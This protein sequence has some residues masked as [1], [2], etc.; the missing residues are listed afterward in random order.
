MRTDIHS[1]K[2]I[3]PENYNFVACKYLGTGLADWSYLHQ[4]NNII[5]QHKK[6]TEGRMASHEHGGTCHICGAYALYIAVFHHPPTNEYIET[7]FDCAEK[8]EISAQGM[9]LFQKRVRAELQIMKGK[10]AALHKLD[11]Y[12]LPHLKHH[13]TAS[14]EKIMQEIGDVPAFVKAPIATI[15]DIIQKLVRY[16]SLSEKQ[17]QF[18]RQLEAQFKNAKARLAV[19]KKEAVLAEDCPNT[20]A[21]VTIDGE[22]LTL[23]WIDSMY[24]ASRKML[25]KTPKGYKLWGSVPSADFEIEVG[26]RIKFNAKIERS[27]DDPKFGFFKRPTKPQQI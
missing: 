14:F 1:P 5:E 10:E 9:N 26:S 27:N 12:G 11:V 3:K 23:K 8:L 22:I 15:N 24:G 25:I 6:R 7:G 17:I 4:Q 2:N 18:I 19:Q 21:R 20:N 13:V 16:G